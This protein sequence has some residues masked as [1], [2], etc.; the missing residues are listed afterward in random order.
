MLF[1][2]S[3]VTLELTVK[4]TK[5]NT[6][7]SLAVVASII[8]WHNLANI[9]FRYELRL[10]GLYSSWVT[11]ANKNFYHAYFFDYGTVFLP[12]NLNKLQISHLA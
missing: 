1:I 3:K 11:L 4:F 10:S 7:L 12:V 9:N 8:N 6:K 5:M 2:N